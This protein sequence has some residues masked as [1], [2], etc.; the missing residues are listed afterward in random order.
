M[1]EFSQKVLESM[2]DTYYVYALRDSGTGEVFYIGKGKGNRIFS[3]E[4]EAKKNPEAEKENL[5]RIHAIEQSDNRVE[6]IVVH[7]R[8]LEAEALAAEAAL[9]N[10]LTY[11]SPNMLTNIQGGHH[12]HGAMNVEAYSDHCGAEELPLSEIL[13]NVIVIKINR[14]YTSDLELEDIKEKV[15][16]H[17]R[18]S[19]RRASKA[20]YIFAVY[21]GLIVGIYELERWYSSTEITPMFPRPKEIGTRD[22]ANR[23]YC[24]CQTV[25]P[26]SEVGKRYFKKTISA[27][28]KATRNPISYIGDFS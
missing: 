1:K 22:L 5:A 24:T 28:S 19:Q 20:K 27:F 17:W 6:R 16:G 10:Y 12:S 23:K 21:R 4:I 7:D 8:L 14:L 26:E 2:G 13:E 15:R 18:I 25:L 9:I 3:H 11:V